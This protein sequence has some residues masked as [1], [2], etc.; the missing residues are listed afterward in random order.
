MLAPAIKLKDI[1]RAFQ[2]RCAT[3]RG[4]IVSTFFSTIWEINT[5]KML[6]ILKSDNSV[7]INDMQNLFIRP[8]GK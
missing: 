1:L 6:L 7:A 3:E 4:M 8:N 2:Q 5:F